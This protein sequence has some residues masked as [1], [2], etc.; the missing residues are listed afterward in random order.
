MI[1]DINSEDRLVQKTFADHLHDVL[2]WDSIYAF[3]EETFG[4]NG[5]L[6]RA[7]ER[8]VVLVRDLRA[9]L[10]RLN[11]DLPEPAR[12]Q[13]LEKLTRCRFRAL[14]RATEPRFARFHPQRRAGGLARRERRDQIRARAGD[15]FPEWH[16]PPT[17]RLTTG[18]SPSAS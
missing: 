14:A 4:P 18:F 2:G 5:T 1:T 12:E 8:D 11:P 6:G 10:A 16:R 7:S 15:R 3:N 9:A 13:A 17:E